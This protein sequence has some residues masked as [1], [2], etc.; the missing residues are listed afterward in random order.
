MEMTFAKASEMAH[1]ASKLEALEAA[2]TIRP[3]EAEALKKYREKHE[4]IVKELVETKAG[5]SGAK[6][7]ALI[8]LDDE[9]YGA[10]KAAGDFI[11]NGDLQSAKEA[12]AKYRDLARQKQEML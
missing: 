9:I 5:Y 10:Y 3:A 4:A 6:S 8:N 12:Y 11:K 7:E 1:V 2:G